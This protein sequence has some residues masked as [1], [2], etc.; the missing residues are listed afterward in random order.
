MAL[1]ERS[2]FAA[3]ILAFMPTGTELSTPSHAEIYTVYTESIMLSRKGKIQ[4]QQCFILS[5][6]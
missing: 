4:L 1:F 6:K 3:R 2:I 5:K